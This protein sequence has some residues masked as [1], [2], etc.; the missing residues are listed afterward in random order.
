MVTTP[1]PHLG[2]YNVIG[3]AQVVEWIAG[4]LSQARSAKR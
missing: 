3:K 2:R 4:Y 1:L